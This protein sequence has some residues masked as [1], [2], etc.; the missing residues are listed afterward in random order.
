MKQVC[1][2]SRTRDE[3]GNIVKRNLNDYVN[4]LNASCVGYETMQISVVE[5]YEDN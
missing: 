1:G 3:K 2:L 4:C 5:V